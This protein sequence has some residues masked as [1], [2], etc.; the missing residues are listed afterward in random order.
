VE[1]GCSST[2][3]VLT[4]SN[5]SA[6]DGQTGAFTA[7][8]PPAERTNPSSAVHPNWW[9]DDPDSAAAEGIHPGA[10]NVNR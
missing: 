6:L 1:G 9:I 7:A 3:V 2:L 10:K 4:R 5:V 8:P